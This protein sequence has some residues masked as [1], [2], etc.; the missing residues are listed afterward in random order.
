MAQAWNSLG[1]GGGS[2]V[3]AVLELVADGPIGPTQ[4]RAMLQQVLAAQEG[5]GGLTAQARALSAT[6]R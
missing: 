3:L 4:G 2:P 6:G 5:E 1:G